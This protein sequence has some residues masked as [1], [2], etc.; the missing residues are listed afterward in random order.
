MHEELQVICIPS[1][2]A[3]PLSLLSFCISYAPLASNS[4]NAL[5]GWNKHQMHINLML[6]SLRRTVHPLKDQTVY[7]SL[8]V[9]ME[10]VRKADAHVSGRTWHCHDSGMVLWIRWAIFS[11]SWLWGKKLYWVVYRENP[12]TWISHGAFTELKEWMRDY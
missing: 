3:W 9:W 5:A 6:S 4:S 8:D 1:R 11:K 7:L 10:C 12:S 2:N